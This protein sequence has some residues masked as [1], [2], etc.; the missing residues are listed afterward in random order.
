MVSEKKI[1][2]V[3]A[4]TAPSDQASGPGILEDEEAKKLSYGQLDAAAEFLRQHEGEFSDITEAEMRKVLW[5]I[6][7]RLMPLL[8][9]TI[10]MAAVDV[11]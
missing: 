11:S 5:K 1:G 8:V 2:E 4:I 9:V 6:D 10:T 3:D 7:L